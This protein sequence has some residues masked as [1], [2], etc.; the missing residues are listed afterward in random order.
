MTNNNTTIS[1]NTLVG[2]QWDGEALEA[3]NNVA[4]ALLNLTELFKSQNIHIEMIS[5]KNESDKKS[6]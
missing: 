4:K 6:N 5:V 3:I 1:N 2:V